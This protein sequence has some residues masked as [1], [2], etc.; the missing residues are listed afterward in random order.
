MDLLLDTHVLLWALADS[1]LLSAKARKL[2]G[3]PANECFFSS[4]SLAEIAIKHRKHP[5]DMVL[6]AGEARAAFLAAGFLELP[7]SA[8]HAEAMDD[9]PPHHADPFDRM[10]LAQTAA[11][12]RKFVSHDDNAALYGEIALPV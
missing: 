11:E 8:R 4:V 1:P 3:D 9:L 10:L 2:V 7:F 6:S 5:D 12:G